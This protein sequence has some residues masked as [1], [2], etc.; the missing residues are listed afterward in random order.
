MP[1]DDDRMLERL[2]RALAPPPAEPTEHEVRVVQLAARR[3]RA[4]WSGGRPP[5]DP[6]PEGRVLQ[7][8]PLVLGRV[9]HP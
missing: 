1:D 9:P 7:L 2:G 6:P 4:R 5:G 3:L 8:P